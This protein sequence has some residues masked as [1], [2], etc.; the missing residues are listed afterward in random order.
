MIAEAHSGCTLVSESRGCCGNGAPEGHHSG[1]G[2]RRVTWMKAMMM[3]MRSMEPGGFGRCS[4]AEWVAC[5]G[6]WGTWREE[7][8]NQARA[9]GLAR[10]LGHKESCAVRAAGGG[11]AGHQASCSGMLPPRCPLR[12]SLEMM[13]R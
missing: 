1:R 6:A 3:D 8:G 7:E 9:V 13:R 12:T 2:K 11:R 5:A 4:E 10:A